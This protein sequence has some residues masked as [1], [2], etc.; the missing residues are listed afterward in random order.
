MAKSAKKKLEEFDAITQTE[1][2]QVGNIF[3]VDF[4]DHIDAVGFVSRNNA[5]EKQS[6]KSGG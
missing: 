6:S 1:K 2:L 5:I 4:F 3:M